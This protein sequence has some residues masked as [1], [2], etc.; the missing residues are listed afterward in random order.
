MQVVGSY[1]CQDSAGCITATIWP[2][3][4]ALRAFRMHLEDQQPVKCA[5]GLVPGPW[6]QSQIIPSSIGP[7]QPK[8]A[9]KPAY[10]SVHQVRF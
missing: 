4:L 2:R 7:F 6:E 8:I 10:K 1:P 3:E 9:R 5:C